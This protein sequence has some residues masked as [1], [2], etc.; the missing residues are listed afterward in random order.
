LPL[1]NVW[2]IVL[3]LYLINIFVFSK[4][5]RNFFKKILIYLF[6]S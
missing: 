1:I 5:F 3:L 6:I 2:L 4:D